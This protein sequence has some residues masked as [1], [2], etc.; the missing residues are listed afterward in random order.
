[1][2]PS[3]SNVAAINQQLNN[4]G[5]INQQ[6]TQLSQQLTGLN[7][8]SQ[9][10]QQFQNFNNSNNSNNNNN[11]NN[12]NT[13][14]NSVP[15]L[16][17]I[18]NKNNNN[19]FSTNTTNNC[20]GN[21][22]NTNSN[23]PNNFIQSDLFQSN[24]ELLSRLQSL[25]LGF[26]NNSI[27]NS[28]SSSNNN[29]NATNSSYLNHILNGN[30]QSPSV[31]SCN[32]SANVINN[33]L[34]LLSSPS[35]RGNFS[36]S[37]VFNR[38]PYSSSPM[39]ENSLP[40]SAIA[41]TASGNSTIDCSSIGADDPQHFLRPISTTPLSG[42]ALTLFDIVGDKPRS[43]TP[44]PASS[45]GNKT[46]LI[47]SSGSSGSIATTIGSGTIRKTD[48]RVTIPDFTLHITDE[49]GNIMN[50]KRLPS[51]ATPS[52]ITRTT[53]EKVP[54]RSQLMSEVQRTAWARHTTK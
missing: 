31:T 39:L 24:Q 9:N 13:M 32:S 23:L 26:N 34:S 50:S 41:V 40:L 46:N 1:M 25:S 51:S 49:C 3:S 10:L 35:N 36:P 18:V 38:S 4:L 43:T 5:T 7:Q 14:I 11:N 22:S 12:L 44:N 48:K 29:V 15:N 19:N 53:S 6:L 27:N 37:P 21:T 45:P 30:V 42:S 28:S 47:T 17:N 8:Q 33:N 52:T 2:T 54:N 20:N 16:N